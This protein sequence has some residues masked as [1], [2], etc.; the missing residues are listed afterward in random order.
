MRRWCCP[1]CFVL[2]RLFLQLCA[3]VGALSG[4]LLALHCLV[5]S[6][7]SLQCS[8]LPALLH[9][10]PAQISVSCWAT[11]FFCP[12]EGQM[13]C[14]LNQHALWTSHLSPVA[15]WQVCVSRL[16]RYP[17]W[18]GSAQCCTLKWHFCCKHSTDS[19]VDSRD[20]WAGSCPSHIVGAEAV[21]DLNV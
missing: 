20:N 18:A 10:C 21:C 5:R 7:Y 14:V 2:F 19:W 8:A 1:V 13:P 9:L 4:A 16:G 17:V 6:A 12:L 15:V 11:C 3:A